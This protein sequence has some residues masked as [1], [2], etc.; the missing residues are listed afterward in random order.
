MKP[1]LQ[2]YHDALEV[3]LPTKAP[4]EPH[5]AAKKVGKGKGA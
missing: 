3:L 1:W 5:F 4:K 2:P